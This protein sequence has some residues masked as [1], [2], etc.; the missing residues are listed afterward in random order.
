MG[1]LKAAARC[2]LASAAGMTL[3]SAPAAAYFSPGEPVPTLVG[4]TTADTL[5]AGEMMFSPWGFASVGVTRNVTL[6]WDWLLGLGGMPAGSVKAR[7]LKKPGFALSAELLAYDLKKDIIDA[8]GEDLVPGYPFVGYK[9]YGT[10]GWLHLAATADLSETVRLHG[11]VGASSHEYYRIWRKEPLPSIVVERRDSVSPDAWLAVERVHNERFRSVLAALY[12]NSFAFNDGVPGK[13][14]V[15]GG[16]AWAPF[17]DTWQ[18]IART[19][20][21]NFV[22]VATNYLEVEKNQGILPYLYLY[23]QFP[24]VKSAGR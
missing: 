7:L 21:V 14:Q 17:P 22:L 12:G 6:E 20:R 23:W 3:F 16:L 18:G 4:V 10:M 13:L 9:I 5:R 2:A 19:L 24:L 8:K 15:F 11:T 1:L